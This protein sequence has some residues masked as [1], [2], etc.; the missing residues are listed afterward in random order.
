VGRVNKFA[1]VLE[2][3]S[4]LHNNIEVQVL[5]LGSKFLINWILLLRFAINI[6]QAVKSDSN[7]GKQVSEHNK[8]KS[9][10]TQAVVL[11][12]DYK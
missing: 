10:V 7:E 1:E 8:Y 3:K 5:N 6:L 4:I 2:R 12:N 9:K 11:E